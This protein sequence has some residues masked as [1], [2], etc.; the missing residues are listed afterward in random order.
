MGVDLDLLPK[1]EVFQKPRSL[2]EPQSQEGKDARMKL[3][4]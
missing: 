3:Q 2:F 4:N 1:A